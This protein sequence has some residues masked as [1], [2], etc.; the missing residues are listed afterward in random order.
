[1]KFIVTKAALGACL[2]AAPGTLQASA[3]NNDDAAASLSEL[4]RQAERNIQKVDGI[5]NERELAERNAA[6]EEQARLSIERGNRLYA[7]GDLAGARKAWREA[8]SITDNPEMER[9]LAEEQRKAMEKAAAERAALQARIERLKAE[10]VSQ[11]ELGRLDASEAKFKEV[12]SLGS[13]DRTVARYLKSRI[14]KARAE[15]A[16]MA[17]AERK[18]KAALAKADK[19]YASGEYAAAKSQWASARSHARTEAT[20]NSIDTSEGRAD[21]EQL[22][23]LNRI[24]TLQSKGTALFG[25]D[26]FEE[27]AA[28]FREVL[29]LKGTHV[30]A[31]QYLDVKIP[32]RKAELAR[33]AEMERRA[34][35]ALADGNALYDSGD[36]K[37]AGAAWQKALSLAQTDGTRS[38]INARIATATDVERQEA[39]ALRARVERLG[40]E[41]AALFSQDSLDASAAKFKELLALDAANVGAKQHLESWIPGRRAELARIGAAEKK[42]DAAFK[43]GNKL[44]AA[45]D[46]VGAKAAWQQAL[47]TAATSATREL[48][49]SRIAAADAEQQALQLRLAGL[50]AEGLALFKSDQLDAAAAKFR[51]VL[52]LKGTHLEAMQY[53]DVKIP[54]RQAELARLAEMEQEAKAA[55]AKGNELFNGG[56][57]AAAD[58]AWKKALELAQS[59]ETRDA[60]SLRLRQLEER[61]E[62]ERAALQ[63][64]TAGLNA[65]G[66]ALFDAGRVDEAEEKFRQALALDSANL[67]ARQYLESRIPE[68]KAELARRAEAEKIAQSAMERGNEL[69]A[70]G[71]F[72]GARIAW[73]E[74]LDI[75]RKQR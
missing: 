32:A 63:V 61:K 69:Y 73:K 68:R 11:F 71:D 31:M 55:L 10:G 70:K 36:R 16:R 24:T 15:Q 34:K 1:M 50:Q 38:S 33:M 22:A 75:T 6:R 35:A 66:I 58:A 42:A 37:G 62:Q 25:Q 39:A 60:V 47:D 7:E 53:L 56:D 40:Q 29:S 19:L 14:P 49:A 13:T 57:E 43:Q 64:R 45:S 5:L 74:A 12:V 72:E 52:A 28:Q 4:I 18:A 48:V 3:V 44:Y 46:Y 9:Y 30:E 51:E 2:L 59:Q 23:L 65:E 54:A 27:A 8:L 41:G 26:R 20:R 21:A 67:G 17:E